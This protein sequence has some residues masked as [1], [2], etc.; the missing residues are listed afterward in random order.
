MNH[1]L[2]QNEVIGNKKDQDI[3]HG[4]PTA[5]CKV[6]EALFVH[7]FAEWLIKQV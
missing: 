1:L 3:K 6:S 5:T 4:I 7:P 2:V